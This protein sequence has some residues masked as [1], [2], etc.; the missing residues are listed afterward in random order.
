MLA[1]SAQC[2]CCHHCHSGSSMPFHVFILFGVILY[3]LC[4]FFS[5]GLLH[6]LLYVVWFC[7]ILVISILPIILHDLM[8]GCFLFLICMVYVLWGLWVYLFGGGSY[9]S[10][11]VP[12]PRFVY[13]MILMIC[14]PSFFLF[15][16]FFLLFPFIYILYSC[17]L[18]HI[19]PS[20]TFF[21]LCEFLTTIG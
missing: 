20:F 21:Q 7:P 8:F 15:P 11:Y 19:A 9:S 14:I 10:V 1:V 17:F 12:P 16:F 2:G 3:A 5:F 6:V 4:P 18:V 13:P